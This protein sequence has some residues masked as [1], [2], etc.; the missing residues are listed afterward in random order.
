MNNKLFVYPFENYLY[1]GFMLDK[2]IY[3]PSV[4]E[5]FLTN[6]NDSG[7]KISFD[8]FHTFRV[9]DEGD[10]IKMLNKF[11][12]EMILGIYTLVDSE[13]LEWFHEQSVGIHLD[14]NITH[15]MVVTV[16]DVIEILS[17]EKPVISK[18]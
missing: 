9:V 3:S 8:W 14:G 7:I 18:I 12:G 17:S 2:L 16:N 15:Y 10:V 1:K 13:Y 4:L 6:D 5:L 11:N